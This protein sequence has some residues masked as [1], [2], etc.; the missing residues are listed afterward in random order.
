MEN[1]SH[2]GLEIIPWQH[3]E[4]EPIFLHV[5]FVLSLVFIEVHSTCMHSIQDK[6]S[7]HLFSQ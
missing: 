1:S 4:G 3:T 6:I 7:I 2:D 5:N